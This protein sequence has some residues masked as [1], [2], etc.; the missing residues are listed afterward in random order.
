MR[1]S[2]CGN[3]EAVFFYSTDIN[4]MKTQGCLCAD[5]ARAEGLTDMG[6]GS[7]GGF[8]GDFLAPERALLRSFGSFGA[9]VRGIMAPSMVMPAA[10][11]PC[12]ETE[13]RIPADAGEDIRR[14]RELGALREQLAAAVQAEDYEKAAELRN[15]LRDMERDN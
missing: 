1:C 8:F 3:N 13:S 4:G 2:R 14:R 5:C 7:F 9:P 10:Y 12:E 6:F 15:K 11:A